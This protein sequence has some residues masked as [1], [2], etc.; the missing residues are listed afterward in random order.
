MPNFTSRR[1]YR[2]FPKRRS[3]ARAAFV[4]GV[5][6]AGSLIAAHAAAGPGSGDATL[7]GPNP[8]T[9][10][11]AG[12]W[13]L[14]YRATEAFA[15]GATIE[16]EIP[17]SW[18]APQDVDAGSPGYFQVGGDP[19]ID[20]VVVVGQ[21]IRLFLAP[22]FAND[23]YLWIYYGIGG[24][25]ASA[26]A[27][28]STQDSVFFQVRSDPQATG[29]VA[30]LA[31]SPFLSVIADPVVASV[32]VVDA[33]NLPVD[34][35]ARTTDQDTTQL[36]LRGYD[37][38]GNPSRLI[39]ADWTLSG[40][41]GAAVPA[42]GTSTALR[43]DVTG[44]GMARAD[45]AGVWADSTGAIT[46]THG[47]YDGL[48]MTAVSSTTAGSA[49]AVTARARDA[50]GNTVSDGAGSLAALRFSAFTD[51]LAGVP[52]DPSFVSA[53]ATLSGG[54]YSGSLTARVKGTFWIAV[55]DTA[56][57][58]VS[59]RHRLDVAA[60][61]PDHLALSPDT[62]RL[63]AGA[64][65]SVTVQVLDPF[66]NRTS[67][68]APETLTLWTDRPNGIFHDLA[69]T[70]TIFEVTIPASK[71]SAR[72]TFTDTRSTTVEGRIRAIDANGASPFLG[73]ADAP[74][75]TTPGV[76]ASIALTATP[77]TLIASGVDS[78]LV[79]GTARDAYGNTVAAGERF[80]LTGSASPPVSPVT[81]DDP[82]APGH[83]LLADAAGHFLGYV[84]VG[85]V[86]GVGSA[87]VS[88]ERGGANSSAS[89]RL[90]P[91]APSGA[92]ALSSPADSV[93]ADS[94]AT[95]GVT[96]SG[97]HDSGGNTVLDGEKYTV[98]TTLGS[99]ATPDADPSTPGRQVAAQGGAI[100]FTL[101][102]GDVLG[103]A[104][105]SA[106][107]VRD[108]TSAGVLSLR[109]VPGAVSA[110][111]SYVTAGSPAA[112]GPTGSIVTVTL[113][114]GQDHPI[115]DIASGSIAV[116]VTGLAATVNALSSATDASGQI[117]FHATASV[118]DTGVVH[119]TAVSAALSAEPSIVFT[120]GPI[121]HY[122]I[123]GPVAPLT[124]G[125]G[126]SL[127]VDAFDA[128][129]NPLPSEGGETLT[130]AVTSGAA[131]V[132]PSVTLANGTAVIPF[133]PTQ[134]T[135]LTIQVSD[136]VRP[137]VTY[138]PVA[139]NP[140]A[141]AVFTLAPDSVV[142]APAQA[143]PVTVTVRDPQGNPIQGHAVTFFLGGPSP[144]GTLESAGG[145]TGGPGS[146]SGVTNSN[147]KLSVRY[148]APLGAPAVDSVFVSGGAPATV[149]I[150]ALTYPGPTAS[151]RVTP[152]SPAWT[153]GIAESVR[154]QPLD[155][156]GNVVTADTAAVTMRGSGS[157]VWNPPSGAPASGLFVSLGT[158][159]V[160]EIV[161]IGADRAG[162]GSG[163][164]G[165][166][167]VGPAAPSGTIAI[168]A[169]RDTLTADGHSAST[170]TLGP[171]HDAFGNLAGPGALIGV[172]A[173]AGTL[174][175]SDQSV[176]FP[177][178]DLLTGT[179]S[180]ASVVLIAA[181]AAGPDTLL[182]LSRAGSGTGSHAFVYLPPPSL[183]YVAGS[184]APGAVTPGAN[185]AFS[186]QVRNTGPGPIQL[187]AGSTLS[188][189][190]G[191]PAYSAALASGATIAS[192]GTATLSF[193]SAVVSGSLPPGSYA[194]SFRAVGTDQ[195][196]ASFDFFPSLAGA[197][198]SVLGVGV[199]AVSASPDPV[200]LGYA[201]LSL[202]FDVTNV[203]GTP[204]S[205]TGASIA[206][207]A[208]AFVTGAPS[209]PLNTTIPANATTRFT[210]PVQVPS[211]G[212]A[213]GTV[214]NAT[215]SAT[216]TYG[217]NPV[218][219]GNVTPLSFTVVSAAQVAAVS[220]ASSPARLLRGRTMAPVARVSN[221]GAASVTL[222]RATTR[223]VL[224]RGV[225]TLSAG[226]SA[227][228]AVAASDQATCVFDSL[229]VPPGTPKGRYRARLFLD[230]VES[231]QAYAD[232]VPFAPDSLDVV[233][234][235]I[236]SVVAGSLA[237]GTVSAGQSRPLSLTL[238]NDGDVAFVVDPSTS[239]RFGAPVSVTRP[240]GL[241]PTVGAGTQ[242]PLTFSGGALGTPGSPG[243]AP[244]S[245]D[246]FGLEDGVAR[247]QGLSA[248]TLHAMAP[249]A[250]QYVA[251]STAPAQTRPG[252]T[253]DVT[254]N[255]RNSGGSPFVLDPGASSLTVTDGTDV[256][257]GFA[258]GAPFTLAPSGQATLSF[259]SL[260]VPGSMASQPYRVDLSLQGTEWGLA[261]T[262]SV[263]SP[264][265]EIVVLDALA[266]IQARALD[267][268][269]PVQVAPGAPPVRV[270]G[271]ELTPLAAMG[272]ATADSLRS[273]AITV[274]TDG[275]AG[276][277]PNG[278]VASIAIRNSL[279][280]L[281]AQSVPGGS[282]PVQ[283]LFQPPVEL[284]NA[285]ESLFVTA[286]FVAGTKAGRVAF[287]LAQ[288][289]DVVAEDVFTGGLVPIVGGGGLPFAALTSPEIT[290]FDKPHGYPNPFHAGSEAI[291]LSYTL[292]QD[293]AVK[294][295][296]YTLFGDLVR[297]IAASAG[298]RGGRTGL[299]ELPW[300]GRNGKGD[301]VRPGV[302][303]AKID[304]PGVSEA[305][306]VG[307][308]R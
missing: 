72:F 193:S 248:D 80:T 232:T 16:V 280:T 93:A 148:R 66:G 171:V 239:L 38:Y 48:E 116:T 120:P 195:T 258:T 27:Q 222:T 199:A 253:I 201:P 123:A 26:H 24:G 159:A 151:L 175:A 89:I 154:V 294:V 144:A 91:G 242:I 78:V 53:D 54:T 135:P 228:T 284:Q 129:G 200:P 103:T 17:P 11:Q 74:V 1:R 277:A 263:S 102:G 19:T 257:T 107:A 272:S 168:T 180:K 15:P 162:G 240:L 174:V 58:F 95:L 302:Y 190:S 255:V 254:L 234:P 127:T 273:I 30:P 21:T 188:F 153:A 7:F 226:L 287:R 99:I 305:V 79:S 141:A 14:Q 23:S 304:G 166:V 290:F 18:S 56:T 207:S 213:P 142:S 205:L 292:S 283:L 268:A 269:P 47:A 288:A 87:T 161:A 286:S 49:F 237:P 96:A 2:A 68:L 230:G 109:L 117:D 130:P 211:S 10:G 301:L 149:G 250:L 147:G 197:Q 88:A 220:G 43:L 92:I 76:P 31:S 170:V 157:V 236:L 145:T 210:F 77:D 98:T 262:A 3:R 214:V 267:V 41:V 279:G 105:V 227:N 206:T 296:I 114:D 40:G 36:F 156:F 176:F 35:L 115:S 137:G 122:T 70:A 12:E 29:T 291:L 186:L 215:L 82:G 256:M 138:G 110:S 179:D 4:F 183:A 131:T 221:S 233:D 108:T 85:T 90:L 97:L 241:A 75:F 39:A 266:G 173:Q 216:L 106:K 298:T 140:S 235:P 83:Q 244:G 119:V 143:R 150:R 25:G 204:G 217:G 295:S 177:G 271:L 100:A 172:S 182:A 278:A 152:V 252:Q 111:Q 306:K 308:L 67:V 73:T 94:T 289:T 69:G 52:A 124:A 9:A 260:S 164:G 281:M 160:A 243:N 259:P 42:N 293:A 121:D 185:A 13:T 104:V 303:V 196:G 65:D 203:S 5:T 20:N 163:N 208:G 55:S 184:I 251:R 224:D 37:A 297:E 165:T 62:L 218:T 61:G 212:I 158:D 46:V 270:W 276:G 60:A 238:R 32:A 194:P 178:L 113:R 192:G 112:V 33:A 34:T 231:G 126:A 128:F 133:T 246:V 134:A 155:A 125:V 45:S 189:G 187:G 6:L 261:T 225:T 139:V 59:E 22:P 8:V 264:D 274:L 181:S 191:A 51:S 209:P 64:P 146:Q 265:S 50:D 169:S 132:P 275:S 300:D 202:Q 57:G 118:A 136:G 198:V 249:A 299:N 81:D 285:P 44:I 223:L 167:T 247:A 307:V 28:T 101:F 86:A 84:S 71:D 229:A 219:G 282:N 245:L 63:I